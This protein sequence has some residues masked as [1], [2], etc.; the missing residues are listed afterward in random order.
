[1][2]LRVKPSIK[3]D[4]LCVILVNY[5]MKENA[6]RLIDKLKETEYPTD[7]YVV[8]NGTDNPVGE[9]KY[10]SLKLHKN[11]QTTNGW[12]MGLHYA[13]S[14]SIID[15]IKYKAYCFLITSLYPADDQ[16]ILSILMANLFK[17]PK[18][19]G[20]EPSL[21]SDSTSSHQHLF[22]KGNNEI[23]SAPYLDNM[24]TIYKSDWFNKNGRFNPE[25]TYAWAIDVET[26]YQ[27]RMDGYKV[28]VDDSVQIKKITNIGYT[29]NRMN[30]SAIDRHNN[31]YNQMNT[32]FSNKYG[33]NW[34]YISRW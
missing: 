5:N 6:D 2:F 24:C 15:K 33:P 32:Y 30:Q 16:D 27:A 1:M 11:V 17:D 13:D 19:V 23:R 14:V 9:S 8:D 34:G 25:M 29:M 3:N 22:N 28:C 10:T 7:F 31:A 21:S 12:L 18:M 4:R 26:G 20:I